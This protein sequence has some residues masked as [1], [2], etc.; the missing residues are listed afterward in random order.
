MALK[1]RQKGAQFLRD[2]MGDQAAEPVIQ[3]GR[4]L[5]SGWNKGEAI[6]RMQAG[7]KGDSRTTVFGPQYNRIIRQG[8]GK[9]QPATNAAE[10]LGAYTNRLLVDIGSD[11]S[12]R[13]YWQYNHPSPIA[14]FLSEKVHLDLS[15]L[16]TQLKKQCLDW[17]F[18][19]LLLL[20][21]AHSTLQ[22]LANSSDPR[23]TP[24]NIL[25]KVPMI[26]GKL[27]KL[28]LN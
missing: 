5:V 24:K 28:V 15:R 13:V 11:S 25:R 17:L 6:T 18:L 26:V 3:T 9:L 4:D 20:A 8:E 19:L 12:R 10:L 2:F 1:L 23:V 7:P 21:L 16:R 14:D 22:I 27:V